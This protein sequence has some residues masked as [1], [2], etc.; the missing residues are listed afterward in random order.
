[1]ANLR[2]NKRKS[3]RKGVGSRGCKKSVHIVDNKC[4]INGNKKNVNIENITKKKI[5][6]KPAEHS[7]SSDDYF[8]FVNFKILMEMIAVGNKCQECGEANVTITDNLD[9]RKG[10]SHNIVYFCRKCKNKSHKYTSP[11][12]ASEKMYGCKPSEINVRLVMAFQEIG[13]G[14]ESIK[15]F[16]RFM[17]MHSISNTAFRNNNNKLFSAY[18]NSAIESMQNA[19]NEAKMEEIV[20]G[21]HSCR[22]SI[23]GKKE[24]T[25]H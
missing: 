7:G 5:T 8:L 3:S 13:K 21:I 11:F 12:S 16:A 14:Y 10:F 25:P 24:D 9:D 2:N 20:P 17:N 6:I 22:V 18:E 15:T 23:D 19:A 1:M 4:G